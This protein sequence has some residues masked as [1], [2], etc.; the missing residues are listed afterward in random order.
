MANEK[1]ILIKLAQKASGSKRTTIINGSRDAMTA[2]EIRKVMDMPLHPSSR[3]PLQ[4]RDGTFN[5]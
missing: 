4:D 1:D 5:R 2:N 3:I